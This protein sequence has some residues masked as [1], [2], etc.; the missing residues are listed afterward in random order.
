ML[1]LFTYAILT[2]LVFH[3]LIAKFW[4]II[5][6]EGFQMKCPSIDFT[7]IR[8]WYQQLHVVHEII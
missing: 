5:F 8:G 1:M 3:F 6:V 2:E 7:N 4:Y